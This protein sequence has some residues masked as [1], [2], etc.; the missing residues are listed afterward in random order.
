MFPLMTRSQGK[1]VV[2]VVLDFSIAISGYFVQHT[3]RQ[4]CNTLADGVGSKSSSK[5]IY[6]RLAA[7]HEW[8]SSAL[9]CRASAL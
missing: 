2:V 7:S 1:P 5:C 3:A 9:S 4:A 8:G 6:I